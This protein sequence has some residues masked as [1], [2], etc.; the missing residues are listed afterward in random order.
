[1]KESR[2]EEDINIINC[3]FEFQE[4][5]GCQYVLETED[6]RA[7]K[8]LLSD[9][10]RVL[11]ESE[12]LKNNTRKNENEFE[13]AVDCDLEELQKILDISEKSDEYVIYKDEKWIK[14]K[15]CVPVQKVK[16]KIEELEQEIKEYIETDNTGR[17]TR[18][19]CILTSEVNVLRELLERE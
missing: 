2:I 13:F 19:N 1:M 7:I 10:K 12:E 15:Y 4:K 18:E 11:K 17:F 14:E 8:H 9:Y 6:E 16:N 3:I 5:M